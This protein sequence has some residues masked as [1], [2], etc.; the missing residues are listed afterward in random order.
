VAE[1]GEGRRFCFAMESGLPAA[2]ENRLPQPLP[3][4]AVCRS[5][6]L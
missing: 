4:R 5:I 6:A 2:P 1:D 3:A